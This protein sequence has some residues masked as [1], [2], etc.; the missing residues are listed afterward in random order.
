MMQIAKYPHRVS[1]SYY[2]DFDRSFDPEPTPVYKS[3]MQ[4]DW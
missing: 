3:K 4:V 1:E 2:R